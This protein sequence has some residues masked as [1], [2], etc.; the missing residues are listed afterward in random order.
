M[1]GRKVSYKKL[2][3]YMKHKNEIIDITTTEFCQGRQV[4]WGLAWRVKSKEQIND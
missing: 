2:L 1:V 4:R 3:G